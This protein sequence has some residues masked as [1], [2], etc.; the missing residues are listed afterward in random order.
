MDKK[1]TL[2]QHLRESMKAG[3]VVRK[4]TL[5]MALAAIKLAEV[6]RR[7]PLDDEAILGVL[8]KEVKTRHEAIADAE[9]AA[10][11]DL[12]DSAKAELEVLQNYLPQPLTG[13]ELESLVRQAIAE[14]GATSVKE[15][16][17]VMKLL[18]PRLQGRADGKVASEKVRALLATD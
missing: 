4:R 2:E 17:Q 13:D 12:I 15:T 14:S 6:E 11:P 10:R 18:I 8:Q 3:D 16:G 7:G 1:A 9:K 5:R